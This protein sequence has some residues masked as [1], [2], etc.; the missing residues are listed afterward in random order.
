[1][2][3]LRQAYDEASGLLSP[4]V[5][6]GMRAI[7]VIASMESEAAGPSYS[8][9]R[10][11]EAV[12]AQG[13]TSG[14]VTTG[15]FLDQHINSVH[16]RAFPLTATAS[17]FSRRLR[18]S[19]GLRR[20]LDL[21]AAAGA[22]LHNHGLWTM[23]NLCASWSARRYGVPLVVS[24]RGMLGAAALLYSRRKKQVFWTLA[25]RQAIEA[26]SCLHATSRSEG[27]EIRALGI[28]A[29][30]AVVPNGVDVPLMSDVGT[31]SRLETSTTRTVLHLGRIH[32]KKGI[33]RLIAAWARIEATHPNWRLRIVGPSEVGHKRDLQR[34]AA[35]CGVKRIIFEDPLFGA[36]KEAAYRQADLFVLPT[37]N[38]NFGMVVAEA[39]AQGRPVISTKGAPW[40]G[41]VTH[42]CG[43]WI[44]HGPEPLAAALASAM[45][46][47]RFTL[48][49]MGLRGREWMI[50][51]Y[52]W[53]R[54]AADM[55]RVY[56]WCLGQG[57]R[58]DD[59]V[60]LS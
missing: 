21:D 20:A 16:W 51:E 30:V 7:H 25:Q 54:V 2:S 50:R 47:P 37:L 8:V 45:A 29:P 52:S 4:T 57:E 38:E 44:D 55:L 49:E 26:A 42:R 6:Q 39:L 53:Q 32:P 11:A 15:S 31:Q 36:E 34:Q 5:G 12:A 24:P 46:M 58:P 48:D 56:L 60:V 41:L 33:D 43:W 17:P 14:I 18:S 13:L 10:L 1:M 9:R 3:L 22:I 35:D 27:E 23:P 28:R 59:L 40:E 19:K